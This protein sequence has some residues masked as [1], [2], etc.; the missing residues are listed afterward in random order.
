MN[1]YFRVSK[2]LVA[3]FFICLLGFAPEAQAQN[4]QDLSKRSQPYLRMKSGLPD[5]RVRQLAADNAATAEQEEESRRSLPPHLQKLPPQ[6]PAQMLRLQP[7][8]TKSP[9]LPPGFRPPG[10]FFRPWEQRQNRLQQTQ[11]LSKSAAVPSAA[12]FMSS[13]L[14]EDWVARHNESESLND[15]AVDVAVDGDGNVYVAGYTASSSEFDYL[16]IKYNAAGVQQWKARY[17][18]PGNSYDSANALAIDAS[19][20]GDYATLK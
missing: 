18:G 14:S 11:P 3:A 17:N 15:Y 5:P 20:N 13:C 16:T 4:R 9:H 7:D 10:K 6:T 19:G 2:L 1:G 12:Q 8:E